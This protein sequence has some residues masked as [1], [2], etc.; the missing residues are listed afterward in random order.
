ML[1]YMAMSHESYMKRC[2][3][4]AGQALGFVQ[5]NP[6]VGA[7][8]VREDGS[9]IAEGYHARYGAPHAEC[10]AIS[11]A[12]DTDL[13][14]A[15][16]YV[17]LEPCSHFGKTPP[18]ADLIIQKKIPRVIIGSMDS[19]PKVSG[20][21]ISRLREHGIEV[22][23]GVLEEE[24]RELNRRFFT[25]HEKERPYIF[26][27]WAETCDGFIARDDRSSKWISSEA[28]R[29]L[30]H[31]WRSEEQAIIVGTNTALIDNPSLTVRHIPG[32]NPLRI[33]IDKDLSIPY[34]HN[35]FSKD[36]PTWILNSVRDGLNGNVRYL[37][38]ND[39][40]NLLQDLMARLHREGIQSLIVEGG[41]NL[42]DSFVEKRLWDEAR[43]F[44]SGTTFGRGLPSP[45]IQGIVV[46][47]TQ[48][49]SD[50]LTISRNV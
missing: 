13:Q 27:K 14:N 25:F 47:I 3:E 19:N 39:W 33:V 24:C 45:K 40:E 48:V 2:L 11:K 10:D 35:I 15:T 9:L 23:S 21:G 31:R 5:P 20:K 1:Y 37:L 26:L 41:T 30:V 36:A 22:I 18:C 8:L 43:V 44:K 28:S 17:N 49:D 50:E 32:R 38:F 4:L 34:T 46:K 7:I 29:A 12:L 42:I 16:L 6:M